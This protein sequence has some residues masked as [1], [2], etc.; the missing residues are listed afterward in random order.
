MA[1]NVDLFKVLA[2]EFAAT[3]QPTLDL[4]AA[5]A[6]RFVPVDVWLAKADLGLVYMTAHML[7]QAKDAAENTGSLVSTKVGDLERRFASTG[8]SDDELDSTVYGQRYKAARR[9]L[10]IS[11]FVVS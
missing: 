5:E 9:T 10:I 4:V 6:A 3:P 1:L 11:P 2:P 8:D 7:K